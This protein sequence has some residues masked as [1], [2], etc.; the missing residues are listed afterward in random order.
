MQSPAIGVEEA[1]DIQA[2]VGRILSDLGRPE[3]PLSLLAVREL[4]KLDLGY[5]SSSDTTLVDDVVHTIRM[6]GLGLIRNPNSS[7]ERHQGTKALRALGATTAPNPHRP[8]RAVSAAPL[9]GGS[10]NRPQP[11]SMAPGVSPR[12]RC[13]HT[14]PELPRY[15]RGR[16]QLRSGS[17]PFPWRRLSARRCRS[18]VHNSQC[19]GFG[20]AIRQFARLYLVACGGGTRH[21]PSIVR[22]GQRASKAQKNS[23]ERRRSSSEALH[24]VAGLPEGIFL[25]DR[26]ASLLR[27]PSTHHLVQQRTGHGCGSEFAGRE[28]RGA[29]L[30]RGELLYRPRR[31]HA[32]HGH[33]MPRAGR[34]LGAPAARERQP[35]AC[36]AL[37]SRARRGPA[38][39]YR[40]GLDGGAVSDQLGSPGDML[41]G[42]PIGQADAWP[43]VRRHALAAGIAAPIGCHTFRATGITVIC[44]TAARSNTPRPWGA[45]EP[46]DN[47]ALRPHPRG[48]FA[49]RFSCSL[50]SPPSP[51]KVR[52]YML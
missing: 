51:T 21:P 1:S 48:V 12:R 5:Y 24:H 45:R 36:H 44:S 41:S 35:A 33:L 30:S 40:G 23:P 47:Q 31:P 16:G 29:T 2:Q 25:D 20:E 26:R 49:N 50:L 13:P 14:R 52:S 32:W 43:M 6:A 38:R 27:P 42:Q 34:R 17:A 39:I 18:P 37:P 8:G 28:R 9:D 7:V 10:R 22:I 15:H 46:A 19:P 3:P 11:D 4:L